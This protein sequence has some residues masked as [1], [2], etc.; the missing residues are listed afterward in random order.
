MNPALRARAISVTL[1]QRTFTMALPL[2]RIVSA[3]AP[4]VMNAYELYRRRRDIQDGGLPT[5][6]PP[7]SKSSES[8]PKALQDLR[9]AD[10]EQARVVSELSKTVEALALTLQREI[11]EGSRRETRLR[12]LAWIAVAS[13]VVSLGVSV[14]LGVR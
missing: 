14:W 1:I 4:L 2:V 9:D 13:A 8:V 12:Q 11:E 7:F 3:L 5:G 6:E 10:V